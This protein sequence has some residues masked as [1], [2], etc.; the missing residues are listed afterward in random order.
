MAATLLPE[1]QQ[2]IQPAFVCN[3]VY[4]NGDNV[5]HLSSHVCGLQKCC[6]LIFEFATILLKTFSQYLSLF[7]NTAIQKFTSQFWRDL[8]EE[9]VLSIID[10]PCSSI[11]QLRMLHCQFSKYPAGI[12][13]RGRQEKR[14]FF[15]VSSDNNIAVK[16]QKSS[17]QGCG[18]KFRIG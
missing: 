13:C 17:E 12:V 11:D 16:T 8:L 1:E 5:H 2:S 14:G 9:S 4:F 3:S 10:S 6:K 15:I 7:P 18:M